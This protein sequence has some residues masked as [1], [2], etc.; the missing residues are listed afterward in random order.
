MGVDG[1]A[2][3]ASAHRDIGDRAFE[4]HPERKRAYFVDIRIGMVANAAFVRPA[5]I[6]ILH[7]I[8]PEKPRRAVVHFY[9]YRD[10]DFPLRLRKAQPEIFRNRMDR[11]NPLE[12]LL[13]L[14]ER[15]RHKER[16]IP[17]AR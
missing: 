14:L 15:V 2:A 4:R 13:R 9:G 1:Y 17:D 5:Q 7:A 8:P 3:L 16:I 10:S 12:L 6:R 11:Q